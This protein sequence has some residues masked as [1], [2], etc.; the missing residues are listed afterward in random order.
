MNFTAFYDDVIVD[1][2]RA[3][4]GVVL[5]MARLATIELCNRSF[6]WQFTTGELATVQGQSAYALPLPAD[7]EFV[8]L[9]DAQYDG[10]P[11]DVKSV[12]WLDAYYAD[13]RNATGTPRYAV[14]RTEQSGIGGVTVVPTPDAAVASVLRFRVAIRPTLAATAFDPDGNFSGEF[15]EDIVSGVKA[16]LMASPGKPYTNLKIAEY[17]FKKFQAGIN[18]AR[19]YALRNL[20][21]IEMRLEI[22]R[23]V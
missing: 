18:R 8:Q 23:T 6:I 22:P 10:A 4:L 19:I 3:A 14:K 2:S 17:H 5:A 11:I 16:R 13:W 7:T 9:L 15:Y 20:G 21:R 1:C 12:D